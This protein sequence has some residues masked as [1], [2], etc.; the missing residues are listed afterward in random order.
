[1]IHAQIQVSELILQGASRTKEQ[2]VPT[3]IAAAEQ[4]VASQGVLP[5]E[6]F[7]CLGTEIGED[8]IVTEDMEL[9]VT[10]MQY[11]CYC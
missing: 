7:F 5:D 10:G 11:G 6:M 4:I 9:I 3:G 2:V 8:L 1:M